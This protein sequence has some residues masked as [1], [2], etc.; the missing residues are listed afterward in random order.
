[1]ERLT[2]RRKKGL[3]THR[4]KSGGVQYIV[5]SGER[6]KVLPQDLGSSIIGYDCLDGKI[7][8]DAVIPAA[9]I[10]E[11]VPDEARGWYNVVN[12]DFPTRPLND[13]RLRKGE[14]ELFLRNL[15][16]GKDN[17]NG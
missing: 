12:P 15:I 5:R 9:R 1:M 4:F 13:K 16:G 14:A 7:P 2:F 3:G 6:V 10:P 8:A 11:I 17:G